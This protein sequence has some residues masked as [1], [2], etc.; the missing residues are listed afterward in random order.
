[1]DKF[2]KWQQ[3]HGGYSTDELNADTST[4]DEK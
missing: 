2:R 1:M 3:Q 4:G